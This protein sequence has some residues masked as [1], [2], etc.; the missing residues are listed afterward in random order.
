[1][2]TQE[3]LEETVEETEQ[4]EETTEEET[5]ETNDE[6][7]LEETEEESEDFDFDAELE[8]L[9]EN[10][11]QNFENA[12]KR[13][14][15]KK[16]KESSMN[17]DELADKV[18]ARITADS[19]KDT[20]EDELAKLSNNPKKQ[21]LIRYHYENSIVKTGVSR[22]SIVGDLENALA[23]TDKKMAAKRSSELAEAKIAES[24]AGRGAG[25]GGGSTKRTSREDYERVLTPSEIAFGKKRGWT[26][27]MFQKAASIKK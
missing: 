1:M 19:A 6:E 10:K 25:M 4:L 14:E 21:E 2:S 5:L 20:F 7:P 17:I 15:A 12:K 11:K 16:P 27:E 24:T 8:A 18:A 26:K 3:H 13:L 23:I 9:K 22:Q